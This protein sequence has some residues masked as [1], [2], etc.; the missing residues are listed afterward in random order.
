M[1]SLMNDADAPGR[2]QSPGPIV[3]GK[4]HFDPNPDYVMELVPIRG[5]K[6]MEELI[7]TASQAKA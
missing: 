1:E 4:F 7:N 6:G 3:I 2:W 5:L